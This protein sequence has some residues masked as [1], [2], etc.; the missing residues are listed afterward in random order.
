MLRRTMGWMTASLCAGALLLSGCGATSTGQATGVGSKRVTLFQ[1]ANGLGGITM[2]VIDLGKGGY[3]TQAVADADDWDEIAL[4][5]SSS[6]LKTPRSASLKL[7]S[8]F[9]TLRQT[10][11][12]TNALT[13]LPPGDDYT[14]TVSL[15]TGSLLIAQGASESISIAAGATRNVTL[16]INTVGP[17]NFFSNDYDIVSGTLSLVNGALGYPE[18]ISGTP[19]E[20]RPTFSQDANTAANQQITG[21]TTEFRDLADNVLIASSS[22]GTQPVSSGSGA[23][24]VTLPTLGL[25][26]NEQVMKVTVFGLNSS[27]N[28]ISTKSRN[29]L[30]VKGGLMNSLLN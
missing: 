30:L 10:T 27:G 6:K 14:L 17:I 2:R 19:I 24:A 11:Y 9:N 15:A 12:S 3:S 18:L 13:Q 26:T 23:Q 22:L 28:V 25:L 16:Y 4:R 21:F 5:V 8:D 7:G 20:V 29:A 1:N